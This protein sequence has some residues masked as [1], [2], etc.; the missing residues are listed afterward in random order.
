GSNNYIFSV[1]GM[2][3]YNDPNYIVYVTMRQPQ[4]M[5][6]SAEKILSEVFNPLVKRLV[7]QGKSQTDSVEEGS[8]YVSV[9]SLLDKSTNSALDKIKNLGLQSGVIGTGDK[10]VQQ[11]PDSGQ[12][13]MLGQRMVLLTNGAMTMPDL[14]GWSKNDVLKFAAITG[15]QVTTKGDGYVVKQ[16]VEAG[17][18]INDSGKIIVTLKNK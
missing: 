4:K 5:T 8:Q 14:N 12:K 13:V 2:I 10:V 11:L 16:S 1:A 6:E 7:S 18:V 17:H 15:K 3:P 9:Q